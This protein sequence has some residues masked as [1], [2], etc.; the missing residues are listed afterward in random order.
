M[1]RVRDCRTCANAIYDEVW[2][3]HKCKIDKK[4]HALQGL[5]TAAGCGYHRKGTPET[6]KNT[7]EGS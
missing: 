2:G 1:E 4:Q 6:T 5:L 3:E 7:Y